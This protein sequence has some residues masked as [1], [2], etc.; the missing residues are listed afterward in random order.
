MP[1]VKEIFD[2]EVE[3]ILEY[4]KSIND[5]ND[6]LE[7]YLF[8]FKELKEIQKII[9][10]NFFYDYS[11]KSIIK[12]DPNF[13]NSTP[14]IVD[15]MNQYNL[16]EL[17]LITIGD[18]INKLDNNYLKNLYSK[19]FEEKSNP[20]FK[21]IVKLESEQITKFDKLRLILSSKINLLREEMRIEQYKKNEL[22]SQQK[23]IPKKEKIRWNGTENQLIYLFD[24]LFEN[25]LLSESE[26]YDE[27][28]SLITKY[29]KNKDGREL[30][31]SKLRISAR[32]VAEGTM[33]KRQV[34][35]ID[36]IIRDVKNKN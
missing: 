32:K 19:F 33:N 16:E 2:F 17:D 11:V 21:L 27:E 14:N 22:V 24:L 25:D 18:W 3:D 23:E 1:R 31:E 15:Y 30:S 28:Y 4:S 6:R 8:L 5:K 7:Y 35:Q 12:R 34:N 26:Y 13:N 20:T 36:K 9:K 10:S 29:F